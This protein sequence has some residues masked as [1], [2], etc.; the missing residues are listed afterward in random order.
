MKEDITKAL[1][2]LQNGG[3]I[4]YPTDTIWGIGC[5]ATNSCAIEN[6]FKIKKRPD[7][8]S[9][10]IL[11]PSINQL[12]RYVDDPPQIAYDLFE[13]ATKPTTI[14]LNGAKNISPRLKAEDGSIAIR[15]PNDPFCNQLLQRFRKPIVSTS[16]NISGVGS[17]GIFIEISNDIKKQIDFIVKWRQD[18]IEASLPSSIVKIGSGN[19]I[20]IIRE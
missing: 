15:I 3:T 8:K 5:D 12:D 10:I 17:P 16:A 14:I 19:Q 11:L 13:F 20:K 4:L 9:M 2:V 18:D 7:A 1:E 6:I